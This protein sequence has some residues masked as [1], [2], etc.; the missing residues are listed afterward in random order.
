MRDA[1]AICWDRLLFSI[2]EAVY[3]AWFPLAARDLG[4]EDAYIVADPRRRQFSARLLVAGLLGEIERS[5]LAGRWHVSDGLIVTA[6]A[7]ATNASVD[8]EGNY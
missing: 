6:I 8:R 4:F 2:K 1:P 7:Q 3:K 5:S